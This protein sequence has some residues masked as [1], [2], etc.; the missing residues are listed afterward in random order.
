MKT[1]FQK[2][3]LASRKFFWSK[4]LHDWEITLAIT[5]RDEPTLKQLTKFLLGEDGFKQ[6]KKNLMNETCDELK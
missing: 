3:P 5:N 2:L 4:V 1:K 6:V